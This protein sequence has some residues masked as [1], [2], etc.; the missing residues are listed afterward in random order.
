MSIPYLWDCL[1]FGAYP[2]NS[3]IINLYTWKFFTK[4]IVNQTFPQLLSA[5]R[6]G[7]LYT[8]SIT[9]DLRS[10]GFIEW[11]IQ[12]SSI[13][14][15]NNNPWVTPASFMIQWSFS[16]SDASMF[17]FSG[18]GVGITTANIS[19]STSNTI[20]I[21]SRLLQKE[22]AVVNNLSNLQFSTHFAYT[23]DGKD[24]RYNSDIIGKSSYHSAS[25]WDIGSQYGVHIIGSIASSVARELTTWQFASSASIFGW[26]SRADIRNSMYKSI[27]LA[28]RNI[29]LNTVWQSIASLSSLPWGSGQQ[30]GVINVGSDTSI[31]K[32]QGNG[33]FF[34]LSAGW[35]SGKRTLVIEGADLYIDRDMYYINPSSITRSDSQKEHCLTVRK[36]LHQSNN[37][38]YHW[39]LC[40]RWF[41]DDEYWWQQSYRYRWYPDTQKS[42]P[43]LWIDRE[44]E[45][46]RMIQGYPCKVPIPSQYHSL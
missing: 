43:Y 38:Q 39:L 22:G 41:C 9:W 34:T 26:L 12:S 29:T 14:I 25:S 46:Y 5:P 2:Y 37:H 18:N 1:F 4:N 10:G 33:W 24:I 19:S 44:W 16:W 35:I 20:W 30:G 15:Q 23:I 27:A 36:S 6:F 13:V 3:D 31:M 7:P 17:S 21:Q 45:Y 8:R 28:T 42:A 32:L 40:D 11:T